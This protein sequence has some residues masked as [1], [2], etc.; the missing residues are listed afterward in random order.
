MHSFD[1]N[2]AHS[3]VREILARASWDDKAFDDQLVGLR[4]GLAD[5]HELG[6][7]VRYEWA[8]CRQAYDFI[9]ESLYQ[10]VLLS[11]LCGLWQ[12]SEDNL[13]R[14]EA[15]ER[16]VVRQPHGWLISNRRAE[17]VAL[18]IAQSQTGWIQ[19]PFAWDDLLQLSLEGL[20]DVVGFDRGRS[21]GELCQALEGADEKGADW[22]RAHSRWNGLFART[23]LGRLRV[24]HLEEANQVEALCASAPV[25]SPF[26]AH[27]QGVVGQDLGNTLAHLAKVFTIAH[28]AAHIVRK[29]QGMVFQSI[30]DA[31]VDADSMAASALWNHRLAIHCEVRHGQGFEALWFAGGLSFY[32]G[33]L[34]FGNLL[35]CVGEPAGANDPR[36]AQAAAQHQRT[37]LRMRAWQEHVMTICASALKHGDNTPLISVQAQHKLM[38]WM[39]RY[40]NAMLD[41]GRIVVPI[42]VRQASIPL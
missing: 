32:F 41:Y 13:R 27:Q 18:E 19:I 17:P 7:L 25:L 8:L 11:T 12:A 15:F 21:L 4:Q 20:L 23:L 39:V 37:V 24:P 38:R 10:H 16:I 6:I 35:R 29:R 3:D 1:G 14:P 26:I 5:L 33:L 28:E 36:T 42:A 2:V 30:E 40:C 22:S 34:V 9:P 31:E